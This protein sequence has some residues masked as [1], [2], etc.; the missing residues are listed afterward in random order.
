MSHPNNKK[1]IQ[2]RGIEFHSNDT[3]IFSI[4]LK[5]YINKE[6]WI[7]R[8]GLSLAQLNP[9]LAYLLEFIQDDK[10]TIKHGEKLSLFSWMVRLNETEDYFEVFEVYPE[11]A[12]FIPGLKITHQLFD[13][14]TFVCNQFNMTPQFPLFDQIV[15]IDPLIKTGKAA[16]LF[17]WNKQ[18]PDSGWIAMTDSFDE[19]LGPFEQVTLGQLMTLRPESG[20]FMALPPGFKVLWNGNDAKIGYDK[21]MNVPDY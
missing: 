17:R 18:D 14:Q 13:R 19:K 16:H 3:A 11:G 1:A 21:N 9:I 8:V 12:G 2:I 5:S 10:L 6:L 20:Q 7:E 15:T 4:G